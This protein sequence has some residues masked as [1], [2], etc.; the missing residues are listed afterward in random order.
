MAATALDATS[1]T[2]GTTDDVAA[3]TSINELQKEATQEHQAQGQKT[4]LALP[5]LAVVEVTDTT[6]RKEWQDQLIAYGIA[7]L[8]SNELYA[9]GRY[10]HVEDEPEIISQIN[11][12]VAQSWMSG[13]S[14]ELVSADDPA[15]LS[16][17][18]KCEAICRIK[19]LQFSTSRIRTIGLVAAGKVTVTLEVEVTIEE[20][21][22]KTYKATGEGKGVTKNL[23]VFFNIRDNKIHFDETTVGQA[24]QQAVRDAVAKLFN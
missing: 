23:G 21:G 19:V 14:P 15:L 18:L 5:R 22:G 3:N 12:M 2:S 8:V 24:V 13:Q 7:D 6:G 11:E 17:R 16:D 20:K 10:T 9:T 1:V 4:A